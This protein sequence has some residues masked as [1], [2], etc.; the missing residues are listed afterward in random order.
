M[1][2]KKKER[3]AQQGFPEP[4]WGKA[5]A[6]R[7]TPGNQPC[8]ISPEEHWG[9]YPL[10]GGGNPAARATAV[11]PPSPPGF[12]LLLVAFETKM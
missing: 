6:M 1:K 4:Q 8:L 2:M 11:S 10:L 5:G 9:A 3:E 7:M 12:P